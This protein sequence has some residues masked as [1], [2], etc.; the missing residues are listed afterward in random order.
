MKKH[1]RKGIE[2]EDTIATPNVL[3]AHYL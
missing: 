3:N 1:F 2:H